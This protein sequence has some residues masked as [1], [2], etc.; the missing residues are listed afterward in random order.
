MG[1]IVIGGAKY[2][3]SVGNPSAIEDAKHTIYSAISG[4]ILALAS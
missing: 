4:L 2:L 1:A 3:T